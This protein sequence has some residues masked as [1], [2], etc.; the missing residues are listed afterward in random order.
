MNRSF[1]Q[2]IQSLM[3]KTLG[4]DWRHWRTR[5]RGVNYGKYGIGIS[6]CRRCGG[7]KHTIMSKGGS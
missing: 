2:G 1:M 3:C 7:L 5:H 6:K 4:H